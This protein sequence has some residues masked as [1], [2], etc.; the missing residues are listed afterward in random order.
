MLAVLALIGA[1]VCL[2]IIGN[3][4]ISPT[5]CTFGGRCDWQSVGTSTGPPQTTYRARL[6]RE[7]MLAESLS[8]QVGFEQ[9]A[10]WGEP[11][12]A[13][14]DELA[15]TK[16]R[17]NLNIDGWAPFNDPLLAA[18]NTDVAASWW[19]SSNRIGM[20][21]YAML[22]FIVTLAVKQWPFNIWATPFLTNYHFDKVSHTMLTREPSY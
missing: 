11:E 20:I 15:P 7:A 10:A 14:W 9:S 22:P 2:C 17:R 5:T 1:A 21:S 3:D 16:T 12:D 19:T 8:E 6:R 18:P 4:Y 13:P